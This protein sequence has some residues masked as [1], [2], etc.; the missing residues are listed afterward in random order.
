[1]PIH[2]YL[3]GHT[4]LKNKIYIYLFYYISKLRYIPQKASW[5]KE[6]FI[7]NV[8]ANMLLFLMLC[9]NKTFICMDIQIGLYRDFFKSILN[10]LT[11]TRK[12]RHLDNR[13]DTLKIRP[14][15]KDYTENRL[16][17]YDYSF[18]RLKEDHDYL[19]SGPEIFQENNP[20]IDDYIKK[21]EKELEGI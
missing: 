1:M 16:S 12:L 7:I 4:H 3:Y 17:T 6:C 20:I 19:T 14:T 15:S 9:E 8:S 2:P 11:K 18:I 13:I 10:Y 5:K 21:R